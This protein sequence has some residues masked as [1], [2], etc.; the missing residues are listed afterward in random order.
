MRIRPSRRQPNPRADV[1]VLS[2]LPY[3]QATR[4]RKAARSYVAQA[5]SVRFVALQG[6][7]RSIVWDEAEEVVREGVHVLQL[8]VREPAR[9]VGIGALLYN[10]LLCYLPAMLRLLATVWRSPAQV[11]H[12]TGTP[13]ALL[14]LMHRL[15]HR[16]IYVLDINERPASASAQASLAGVVARLEPLLLPSLSRFVQIVLCVTP[17]HVPLLARFGLT[18][19]IVVRNAPLSDWRCSFSAPP[20]KEPT[21]LRVIVVGTVFEGRGY[22]LLLESI[23]TCAAYGRV[24]V[25]LDSYGPARPDY[26]RRLQD[27]TSHLGIERLVRW[28]PAVATDEVSVLYARA[29]V[30]LVL[31]EPRDL[32]NDSL[33]NKLLEC[34]ASGRPVLASDNPENRRF[35]SEYAVGW[36][37]PTDSEHV[38][39][40]LISISR[41]G[42]LAAVAQRCW[43]VGD[44]VANWE[45]QFRPVME[46]LR[47]MGYN[48]D[49]SQ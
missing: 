28:H 39:Q 4:P 17:G 7:G 22:E 34:V 41:H 36:L 25:R 35:V 26:M 30:G 33:S 32:A 18:D 3:A 20:P 40:A 19:A 27:L 23:A 42:D 15:R 12:V 45:E 13:F 8:R 31:Y 47:S 16:S 6:A 49:G 5:A 21:E 38:A 46:R 48:P 11:V 29:H 44:R 10:A 24:N 1:L 37:V 9:R 14:G 2:M 43:R